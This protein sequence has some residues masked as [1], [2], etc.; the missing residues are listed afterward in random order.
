MLATARRGWPALLVLPPVALAVLL[1]APEA[2]M[3]WEDH[4]SHFWLVLAAA[5]LS[6]ALALAT[7]EPAR[8]RG[9]AR[10]WL[11][12]L[13]FFS[14]SGFL[15]LHALA[16]PGVL[17]DTPNAGFVYATPAGL[18][19]AG[20]LA[21]ASSLVAGDAGRAVLARARAGRLALVALL[22]LWAA[23]SLGTVWPFGGHEAVEN[24]A[25]S[26]VV[27]AVLGCLLFAFA[28]WRYAAVARR[29]ATP[30][31][32]AVVVAL[33]LL[34]E[35]LAATALA[36]NW[37]LTWWEWHVLLTGA[38][39][40]VAWAA[41][42]EPPEERFAALYLDDVAAGRREVSVLFADAVGFTAFAEARAPSEVKA[43]L[44]AYLAVAV[45]AVV[46]RHGGAIDRLVGDA[47]MATWNTRGDQP[48]HA[49]RAARAALDVLAETDRIA[50]GHPGWPRFRVGVN[51]GPVA[52]GVLGA[53]Q[54]R[55]YTVIGDAANVAARLE[56]LAP[57]G[58]AVVGAATLRALAG[59]RVRP[60]GEVA[61]KGK[62]QPVDA[63][64]LEGLEEAAPAARPDGA[65]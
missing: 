18:V 30:L 50:A 52:A 56:A 39:A 34:A 25:P 10:L 49:Q 7:G 4:P 42:R 1:A 53:G 45:P 48:D 31:V 27:L 12:S 35:A 41:Q 21:A 63:Y 37:H 16:T 26:L 8:R 38:I 54:G 28:A 11:L 33:V 17:L 55:S 24:G 61:V 9:D 13:A 58:G 22:A 59:A 14:A 47:L 19:V 62:S 32:L 46:R 40:L 15:G 51:S 20:A 3:R 23:L 2:D 64:I 29:R 6:A 5:G 43:A 36:R 57:A 65:A 44:D 60:L